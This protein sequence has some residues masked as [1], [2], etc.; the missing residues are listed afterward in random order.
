MKM[1]LQPFPKT[2]IASGDE[3]RRG[4]QRCRPA[5]AVVG[6]KETQKRASLSASVCVGGS[7]GASR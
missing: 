2:L 1:V 7:V 3:R 5:P 4:A 6:V